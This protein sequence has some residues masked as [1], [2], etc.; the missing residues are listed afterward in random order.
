MHHL[1]EENATDVVLA[2]LGDTS[3]PRLKEVMTSFINH[4]HAFIRD[5]EPTEEEWDRAIRFLTKVGQK[6]D[7]DRQ[8]YVLLS[9]TMGATIL[10]DA[11]NHRNEKGATESSVLGPFYVEGAPERAKGADLA[12][13]ADG[14]PVVVRGRVIGTSGQPISGALLDIWQAAPNG[15]YDVQDPS[16]PEFNL[17][18]KV[19]CDTA[20]CYEFHTLKPVSYP[21]PVDGPVGELLRELGRHPYRPAHIHF[22]VTADGFEPLV[23]QLFTAGDRYLESDAA[24]GVKESLIVDYVA[25][26]DGSYLVEYDFVLQPTR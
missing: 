12:E 2:Q 5:I 24:F 25:N 20:G 7:D 14:D 13:A 9:D 19:R 4:L 17:R 26:E 8:E 6:C 23:T 15:L 3:D 22:I 1:T 16:K 21:V 11:I 18:G 10:V